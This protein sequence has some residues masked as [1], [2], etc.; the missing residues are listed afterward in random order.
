[1]RAM[2]LP[3]SARAEMTALPQGDTKRTTPFLIPTGT[4][5]CTGT[6]VRSFSTHGQ[7][8][9]A[10]GSSTPVS[11]S[12]IR[13]IQHFD[14]SALGLGPEV[15]HN[16]L[17]PK[18]T[19]ILHHTPRMRASGAWRGGELPPQLDSSGLAQHAQPPLPQLL[20]PPTGGPRVGLR[21][22]GRRAQPTQ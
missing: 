16:W 7:Q 15:A 17:F 20:L 14:P 13:L 10:Q 18:S 9:A 5:T 12:D 22:G 19:Y 1:M 8:S 2:M 3:S 11:R 6:T 21:V 4:G